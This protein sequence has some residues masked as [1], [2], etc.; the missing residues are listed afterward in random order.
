MPTNTNYQGYP[1]QLQ[2][3]PKNVHTRPLSGNSSS[4]GSNKVHLPPVALALPLEP[5]NVGNPP[6]PARGSAGM[7]P[8][9]ATTYQTN[10]SPLLISKLSP[11]SFH[12]TSSTVTTAASML[13]MC[14]ELQKS[15]SSF[16]SEKLT[17]FTNFCTSPLRE[18]PIIKQ[19][20][21]SPFE[22]EKEPQDLTWHPP[23][24]TSTITST[25]SICHTTRP[26]ITEVTNTEKYQ[27]KQEIEP[28]NSNNNITID[29]DDDEDEDDSSGSNYQKL[30]IC[31]KKVQN[32]PKPL[33]KSSYKNLIK[34]TSIYTDSPKTLTIVSVPDK[35]RKL[36]TDNS[37]KQPSKLKKIKVSNTDFNS[38]IE[39]TIDK[40]IDMCRKNDV[41][42]Q[43]AVVVS[44]S[45]T[46]IDQIPIEHKTVPKLIIKIPEK[47]VQNVS[48]SSPSTVVKLE[49][50][51]VS[52]KGISNRPK[53]ASSTKSKKTKKKS[54][55]NPKPKSKSM[56][57]PKLKKSNKNK[58]EMADVEEPLPVVKVQKKVLK[59]PRWSNGWIWQGEP[60]EAHVFLNVSNI[61]LFF[62]KFKIC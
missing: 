54:K 61:K 37:D 6:S 30:L 25:T 47:V 10:L 31:A 22:K 15:N 21:H 60:Y 39:N 24:T 62:R 49:D 1:C 16:L 29:N 4:N 12:S 27:E 56:S 20:V 36:I 28:V 46:S 34:K 32:S 55:T 3:F 19:E 50:D 7:P 14:H 23:I 53:G 9:G 2:T 8:A 58:V 40:V 48:E 42:E 38:S 44:N 33:N 52:I 26:T 57:S 59:A 43:P 51:D 11:S 18:S 35:K 17:P 45:S 41:N 5:T 13:P